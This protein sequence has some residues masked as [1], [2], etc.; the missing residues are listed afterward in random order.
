MRTAKSLYQGK[1][2]FGMKWEAVPTKISKAKLM[3]TYD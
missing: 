2:G 1:K 3:H